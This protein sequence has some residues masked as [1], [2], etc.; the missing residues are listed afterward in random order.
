VISPEHEPAVMSMS[1]RI[2]PSNSEAEAL[3]DDES[4]E[5]QPAPA[6]V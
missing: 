2:S 6:V 1:R 3:P 5:R 4:A